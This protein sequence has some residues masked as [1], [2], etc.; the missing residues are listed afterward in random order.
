MMITVIQSCTGIIQISDTVGPLF[1][2]YA[3]VRI[4]LISE[5]IC[6]YKDVHSL[7]ALASE[8]QKGGEGVQFPSF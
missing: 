6:E 3:T 8:R 5:W 2:K 1:Q 4:T 7:L